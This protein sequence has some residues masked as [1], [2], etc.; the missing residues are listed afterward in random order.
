MADIIAANY[1]LFSAKTKPL[2]TEADPSAPPPPAATSTA[3]VASTGSTTAFIALAVSCFAAYLSWTS[4]GVIDNALRKVSA[5]GAA[6]AIVNVGKAISAFIS[7]FSYI[8]YFYLLK[9]SR[10]KALAKAML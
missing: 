1:L 3:V 8:V 9:N 7:G 4:N 2:G 6:G 10:V 5:H